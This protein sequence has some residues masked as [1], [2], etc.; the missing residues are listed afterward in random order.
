MQGRF[1]TFSK[2]FFFTSK[3]ISSFGILEVFPLAFDVSLTAC[4][5][6]DSF[7]STVVSHKYAV[8]FT[9]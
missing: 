3:I 8:Y 5:A 9:L 1:V 2:T 4:Y 6:R 7:V